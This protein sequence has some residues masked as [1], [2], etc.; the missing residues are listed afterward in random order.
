MDK[1]SVSKKFRIAKLKAGADGG[2]GLPGRDGVDGKS[3]YVH[4][5]YSPVAN[6]TDGLMTE[7]PSTFIGICGSV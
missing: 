1:L 5:N 7:V 4:I 6:P 3:S 2:Q